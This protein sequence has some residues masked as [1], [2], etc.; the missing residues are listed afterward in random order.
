MRN[1]TTKKLSISGICLALSV[2]LPLT[3]AHIPQIGVAISPMHIPVL[4]CAFLAGPFYAAAVGV[5]APL[6]NFLLRGVP[7]II[8]MGLTMVFELA[9]YGLVAGML[10]LKLPDKAFSVYISLIAAM[11]FG[12]I[13]WGIAA[14]LVFNFAGIPFSFEAFIAAAF[15]NAI[16][17]IILHIVII[18]IIVIALKR[19]GISPAMSYSR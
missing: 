11:F 4:L 12:R 19:A 13:V 7:P 8:P 5:I 1:D 18:P 17:A 14:A 15:T 16:P 10:Y 6:L 9:A 3:I 2:L